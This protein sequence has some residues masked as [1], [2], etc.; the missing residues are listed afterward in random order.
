LLSGL[1]TYVFAAKDGPAEGLKARIDAAVEQP[2][3]EPVR[4]S[5]F[6]SAHT[7][8]CANACRVAV[9]APAK[10]VR[11]THPDRLIGDD[12]LTEGAA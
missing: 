7:S 2:N 12:V 10:V 4:K 9:A 8:I 6:K 11:R 5:I 3:P 1:L